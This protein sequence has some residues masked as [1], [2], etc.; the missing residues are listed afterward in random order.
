M[1][2]LILKTLVTGF[3]SNDEYYFTM[4]IYFKKANK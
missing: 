2:A 1:K 3:Y 4:D